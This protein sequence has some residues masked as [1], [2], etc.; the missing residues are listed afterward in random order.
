MFYNNECQRDDIIIANSYKG[1]AIVLIDV[2]DYICETN[3]KL[4]NT[5]FYKKIS[6][7]PKEYKINKGNNKLK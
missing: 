7:D 2:K 1:G 6:N 4:E 5:E 3:G